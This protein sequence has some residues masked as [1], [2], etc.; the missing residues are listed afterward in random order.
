M[1]VMNL[2]PCLFLVAAVS[3]AA[4]DFSIADYGAMP[5]AVALNTGAIQRAIDAAAAAGGGVVTIPAGVFRSGSLF[6]KAGVELHLDRGA[7]LQ[8]SA[9]IED[10]PKPITRIEGHFEPWRMAL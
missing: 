5:G 1:G 3:V 4:R 9:D 7:V 8:G 2:L 10:Y 6:L